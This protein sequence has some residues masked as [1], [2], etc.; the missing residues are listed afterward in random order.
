M[1][2]SR[3]RPEINGVGVG[4]V[5]H[6]LCHVYERERV[7]VLGVGLG[8]C[9]W[10]CVGNGKLLGAPQL[11]PVIWWCT[12]PVQVPKHTDRHGLL[13]AKKCGKIRPNPP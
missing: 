8:G 5:A 13:G 4:A 9:G 10:G 6:V 1:W 12:V 2:P 7:D 3:D 11:A